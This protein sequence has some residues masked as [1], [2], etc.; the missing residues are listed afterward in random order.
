MV[1]A[2]A[3]RGH[4]RALSGNR[5][6]RAVSRRHDPLPPEPLALPGDGDA[7]LVLGE[8][9]QVEGNAIGAARVDPDHG[10]GRAVESRLW[11]RRIEHADTRN[12]ALAHAARHRHRDLVAKV[13]HASTHPR[14]HRDSATAPSIAKRPAPSFRRRVR[15]AHQRPGRTRPR[16]RSPQAVSLDADRKRIKPGSWLPPAG[17]AAA[18]RPDGP[19]RDSWRRPPW[20]SAPAPARLRDL[21]VIEREQALD[22]VANSLIPID[23]DV[24]PGRGRSGEG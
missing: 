15:P 23:V 13:E 4:E 11:P 18:P 21:G 5:F 14:P 19:E 7:I 3:G 24:A 10:T 8:I 1:F 6:R 22:D 20:R 17:A 9:D 12:T 16:R 2:G